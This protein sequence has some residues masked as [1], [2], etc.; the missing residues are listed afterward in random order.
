NPPAS[1]VGIR[2][3]LHAKP[4]SLD[5]RQAAAVACARS[6]GHLPTSALRPAVGTPAGVEAPFLGTSKDGAQPQSH[7]RAGEHSS[8][9]LG[10][11]G[12]QF[13]HSRWSRNYLDHPEVPVPQSA[14][15]V[16]RT[17]DLQVRSLTNLVAQAISAHRS[18]VTTRF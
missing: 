15:G 7:A 5:T 10:T 6:A 2:E 12:A 14:P 11:L 8:P 16:N 9:W 3:P 17:P 4:I 1:A 18:P 13:G